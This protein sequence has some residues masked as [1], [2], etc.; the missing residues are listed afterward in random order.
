MSEYFVA[1]G[2]YQNPMGKERFE[3]VCPGPGKPPFVMAE[4]VMSYFRLVWQNAHLYRVEKDYTLALIVSS[5]EALARGVKAP[6][7]VTPDKLLLEKLQS[8]IKHES[9]SPA[10]ASS[11]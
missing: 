8:V 11:Q 5:P 2:I 1:G 6:L 4:G 3:L 7:R 10:P 9:L